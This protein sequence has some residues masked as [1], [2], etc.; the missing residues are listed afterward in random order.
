MRRPRLLVLAF[1]P[2]ASDARVLRQVGLLAQ[3]F[4]VTT[5]GY[6]PRPAGVVEHLRLPDDIVAWRT[7]RALL[8][9]RRWQAAYDRAPVVAAAR[10]LLTPG[11]WDAVLANDVQTVPLA[12]TLGARGVHVDLHEYATRQ[13]EDSWRWRRFVAPFHAWILRTW[14][15]RA[16]SVSAVGE[17]LAFAYRNEFGLDPRVVPNAAPYADRAPEPVANP[18]RLVHS[19]LARRSRSLEVM[20]DAVRLTRRPVTLDLYLMPN[21]PA[22]LAELRTA[23]ADL[24]QVRWRDPVAPSQLNAR[25]AQADVGLFVLPPVTF[26]YRYT[27][28]NKLFDFVQARLAVVVGPSPEMARLVH[29]HGC[30][31]VL[32]DFEAASLAATL[33]GLSDEQVLRYKQA[34]HAAAE[35]LSAEQ[36]I[37]GWRDDLEAIVKGRPR[38]RTRRRGALDGASQLADHPRR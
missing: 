30:G 27:L 37:T 20:L 7:N 5:L 38:A 3:D 34:S 12:M 17:A 26:N 9:A 24:P 8:V 21:D 25:L 31:V 10:R 16:A 19:G 11:R 22:Y 18:L 1:S 28:P 6:G 14:V 13:N 15:T 33:E 36:Q 32:P 35:P 4:D 23:S 2:L 29:R